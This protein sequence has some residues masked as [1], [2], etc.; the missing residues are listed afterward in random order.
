MRRGREKDTAIGTATGDIE[1]RRQRARIAPG[2]DPPESLRRQQHRTILLGLRHTSGRGVKEGK[3]IARR[4]AA[5]EVR[6]KCDHIVPARELRVG[7]QSAQNGDV[8]RLDNPPGKVVIDTVEPGPQHRLA[9]LVL[10]TLA[11]CRESSR[12]ARGQREEETGR[13]KR[14]PGIR[15]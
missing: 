2:R 5:V 12:S 14:P 6:E 10:P 9:D 3:K 4:L 11:A 7:Q 1:K 8:A 13:K 15:P